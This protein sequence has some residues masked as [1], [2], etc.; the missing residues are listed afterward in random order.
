[1]ITLIAHAIARVSHERPESAGF[2]RTQPSSRSSSGDSRLFSGASSFAFGAARVTVSHEPFGFAAV[3]S[4]ITSTESSSALSFVPLP[5]SIRSGSP[6]RV[7][8]VSLPSSPRSVSTPGSAHVRE[9]ERPQRVVA[10]AA[11]RLVRAVVPVDGVVAGAA[12]QR[13]VA[14]AAR[15]RVAEVVAVDAVVAVAAVQAVVVAAALDRVV[16]RARRRPGRRSGR[17]R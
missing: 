3:A 8:N 9:R 15:D 12:D 4:T 13:V 5:Q 14:G 17:R 2:A 6:S 7:W 1:M 16:A 11:E 10:G